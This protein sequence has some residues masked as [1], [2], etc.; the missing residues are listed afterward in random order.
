MRG[1]I[2]KYN[3]ERGFGFIEECSGRKIF[4]H[5]NSMESEE[6]IKIGMAVEFQYG[7]NSKGLTAERIRIIQNN[8]EMLELKDNIE[9]LDGTRELPKE[10]VSKDKPKVVIFGRTGSGK[11]S[12]CNA[13]I[14]SYICPIGDFVSC[15]EEVESIDLMIGQLDIQLLDTPGFGECILKDNECE[16]L[17]Q[18]IA[19]DADVILW[20]LRADD[21]TFSLEEKIYDNVIKKYAHNQSS[22]FF[23]L[24]QVDKLEP[25][26]EWN[27]EVHR[28]S[29]I[30]LQSIDFISTEVA[31][32][33]KLPFSKIIPI[34]AKE[35]YNISRLL[36]EIVFVLSSKKSLK[37]V[38]NKIPIDENMPVGSEESDSNFVKTEEVEGNKEKRSFKLFGKEISIIN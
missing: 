36:D 34:S 3:N 25:F 13:L 20:M 16:E 38:E 7:S 26:R 14:G 17:Y 18:T 37:E 9:D 5:I 2:V 23:V 24:N 21:R 29:P 31:R 19:S 11:S 35:K 12:L 30:Q 32:I 33:F 6:E 27:A 1:K 28:P 22:F 10:S 4:F 8:N 15:T